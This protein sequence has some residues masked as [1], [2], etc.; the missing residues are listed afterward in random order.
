MFLRGLKERKKYLLYGILRIYRFLSGYGERPARAAGILGSYL[1]LVIVVLFFIGFTDNAADTVTT[2]RRV[3]Y[4]L[5][6]FLPF[7]VMPIEDSL[8]KSG[9]LDIHWQVIYNLVAALGRL[10][11]VIQAALLT[12]AIRNQL[13]R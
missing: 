2:A 6:D 1:I 13:K 9:R 12:L 4:S 10:F 11:C 5:E 7:F 8:L 3:F